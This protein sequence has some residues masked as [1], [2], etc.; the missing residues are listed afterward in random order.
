MCWAYFNVIVCVPGGIENKAPGTGTQK[1]S[2]SAYKKYTSEVPPPVFPF[3]P[4]ERKIL[5]EN[6]INRRVFS[7]VMDYR[8]GIYKSKGEHRIADYLSDQRIAFDYEYPMAIRDRGMVRI[9]Y[10]DFRLRDYGM[11][12]EYFGVNNDDAYNDQIAHKILTY[13]AAGID[14]IYML[15]SSF[16][17]DWKG[18]ILERIDQ[19][20]SDRL[21][22][23]RSINDRIYAAARARR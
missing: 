18:Q 20:Q 1:S 13:Q 19:V 23:I 11:I 8:R 4:A 16:D 7:P 22:K 17:G 21:D 10:P 14:G 5:T 3:R 6:Y 2:L 15:E 12:L 9:W